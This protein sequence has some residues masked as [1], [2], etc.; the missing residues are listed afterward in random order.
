MLEDAT[1]ALHFI[2][3]GVPIRYPNIRV[4]IPHLGGGLATMLEREGWEFNM[5]VGEGLR[6][7]KDGVEIAPFEIINRLADGELTEKDWIS[8]CSSTGI[9][10][11]K[12]YS[13]ISEPH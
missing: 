4:I 13:A 10:E 11:C 5:K 6:M 12:L 7:S 2:V 3:K 8:L 1:I 9:S